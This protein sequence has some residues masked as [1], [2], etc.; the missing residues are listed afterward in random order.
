VANL[1]I[2]DDD[3]QIC[4]FFSK[5]VKRLGHES[6]FANTLADGLAS[7]TAGRCD[8]VLLDLELPDGSGLSILPDLLETPSAP[9]VIIITGTGN[10][11]GAELAFKYGAWDFIPKPFNPDEVKLAITRALQYRNEKETLK[12]PKLL[13]REGIVGT[14]PALETCL[15]RVAHAAVTE[16]AVLI[17]GETGS[18]KELI[19]RAIHSNSVRAKGG[20]VVVD[21]ASLP[22]SLIESAL[23][24]HEKGAF[25]GA[26]AGRPGLIRQARGGTLFLDEVG[27]LP[28]AM[29]K[30]FLRVLQERRYRPV[31]SDTEVHSDFRLVAATH[32]DLDAMAAAGEFREDLLYRLRSMDIYVP[33][34]RE[35]KED[36]NSLVVH[37]LEQK[38][39]SAGISLKGCSSEFIQILQEYDWPGN[40]RELLN[41]VDR[42]LAVA[43][44]APTLYPIHLP[45]RIRLPMLKGQLTDGGPEVQHDHEAMLQG[46]TLPTIREYRDNLIETAERDYLTELMRRTHGSIKTACEVSGLS[47]SR[48]HALLKKYEVPRFRNTQG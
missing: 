5:L 22:E 8:L 28:P 29:Q 33:P 18:G 47:G 15:E 4:L 1:L 17:T 2:I 30:T 31:G 6:H 48:L 16:T 7:C 37:H 26:A 46:Q 41:A 13:S 21:C 38:S 23:F 12:P 43:G 11:Q 25:T 35:R 36:I 14:S 9:E 3:T 27:E 39:A 45:S 32:R 40:V 42:A 10:L 24:G 44:S 19:A 34:L 20:F